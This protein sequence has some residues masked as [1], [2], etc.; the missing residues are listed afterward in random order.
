M[1]NIWNAAFVYDNLADD[2]LITASSY[3]VLMPPARLQDEQPRRY[4]R[5]TSALNQYLTFDLGAAHSFDTVALINTNLT[6]AGVTRLRSSLTD[7]TG[8]DGAAYNGASAA[9]RVDPSYKSLGFVLP[10]VVSGRHLRID[11]SDA[12]L[13]ASAD[14]NFVQA[15]F[16]VIGQRTQVEVSFAPGAS[17][18]RISNSRKTKGPSG[19]TFIDPGVKARVWNVEFKSIRP[20]EAN[21]FFEAMEI[22]NG[23]DVSVLFVRNPSSDNFG[24]DAILALV[25]ELAPIV[26]PSPNVWAKSFQ[27]EERV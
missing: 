20:F 17:R 19:A 27:L 18:K 22:A 9:G 21:G 24:R 10:S 2:A 6:A 25:T 12:T 5:S 13:A 4:W 3:A 1:P 23:D 14:T 15:G 8:Q 16:V 26:Q 11:L 7:A